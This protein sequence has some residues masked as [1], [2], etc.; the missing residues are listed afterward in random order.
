MAV[1]ADVH[2][3]AGGAVCPSTTIVVDSYILGGDTLTLHCRLH[4]GAY[5]W[6]RIHIE[7]WNLYLYEGAVGEGVATNR[8]RDLA[9]DV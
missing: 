7:D 4:Q 5:F 6:L 3:F 9:I 2:A 1:S 8:G